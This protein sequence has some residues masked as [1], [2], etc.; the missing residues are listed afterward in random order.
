MATNQAVY[1]QEQTEAMMDDTTQNPVSTEDRAE[2]QV[3]LV[4][5]GGKPFVPSE[6]FDAL[7][8]IGDVQTDFVPARNNYN[9]IITPTP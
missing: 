9:F 8:E 4:F 2:V 1:T 6:L 5:T 7:Q 3:T